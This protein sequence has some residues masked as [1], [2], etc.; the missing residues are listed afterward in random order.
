MADNDFGIQNNPDPNIQMSPPAADTPQRS[1]SPE[2]TK[3][4]LRAAIQGSNEVLAT[5]TTVIPL[6]PDTITVDRAKFT[7]TQRKFFRVAETMSMRIEDI[8]NVTSTVG[9]IFGNVKIVS[10]VMAAET[11]HTIGPFWRGEAERLKRVTQ[12][13]V[14]ALQRNIDCSSLSTKELADMLDKLGA[15]SHDNV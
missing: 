13:Y 6:F 7:I 10:R 15:D 2:E 12:G 1:T 8:L 9:P 11:P 3:Q 4:E 5:A 14:I